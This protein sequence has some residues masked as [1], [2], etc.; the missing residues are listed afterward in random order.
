MSIRLPLQ[1][2]VDFTTTDLGAASVAGGI[3]IPF[4]I[5][6]DTDNI[7]VK[8]T[9]SVVTGH[10]RVILQTTDDG[11]TTWYDTQ[12]TSAISLAAQPEWLSVPVISAGINPIVR[13]NAAAGSVLGGSIGNAAASTLSS[14]QV[15]GMPIL[16]IQNRAFLIIAGGA[17]INSGTR[18]QV[19]V[20]SQS[21]TA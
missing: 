15:S 1:G 4:K 20:N 18:V 12:S 5:P 16:G 19:M 6:Q 7:L 21:A 13:A 9:P 10:A 8:L 2:I 3:A 14:R 11:G 17:T